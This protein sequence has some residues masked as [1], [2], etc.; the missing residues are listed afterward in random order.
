MSRLLLSVLS[1][2]ALLLFQGCYLVEQGVGQF[3]LRFDQI[4]ID[5]AI[6]AE[7]NESF[8]KL[9]SDIP[10]IKQYAI[11]E[12]HL[13]ATDNYT[14]YY[15]ITGQGVAYVVTACPKTSLKPHTWWFPIIG[16]VPY[17]GYFEKEDALELERQLKEDGFDTWMFAAPAY[18]T[19]GWFKDPVT[20]P[21]L[22]RGKFY[23]TSTIIHEMVHATFYIKGQ[24]TF[25]EQLASFVEQKGARGYFEHNGLL[26]EQFRIKLEQNKRNRIRFRAIVQ[27]YLGKLN[28]LYNSNIDEEIKLHRRKDQFLLLK[29]ELVQ[30]YP[31]KPARRWEFNNARLLQYKR[32]DGNSDLLE[33]L[34]Q[35]SGEDWTVFWENVKLYVKSQ[36]WDG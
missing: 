14:G 27:K 36:G 1:L 11:S 28:E 21:M 16:S 33:N 13:K 24:G 31:E 32:Y 19:L 35:E 17:K 12:L 29:A 5:E 22:R 3:R 4:P 34:W 9:L 7:E 30:L 23:L 15:K 10:S 8:K 6:S 25:N 18:S 26:D 2:T 20:T